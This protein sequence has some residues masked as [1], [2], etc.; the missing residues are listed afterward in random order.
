MKSALSFS[1]FCSL[2][3]L[4]AASTAYATSMNDITPE[5]RQDVECMQRT[6][7]SVPGVDGTEI[8][9][10]D[11]DGWSHPF[12]QYLAPPRPYGYRPT[13]RF[14]AT[15]NFYS[16]S[17]RKPFFIVALSGIASPGEDPPTYG[18]G[19]VAKLWEEKCDVHAMVLFP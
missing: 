1:A 8:G 12:I 17:D 9:V 15:K 19:A 6:L 3:V 13:I 7:K 16:S 11:T 2:A 5:L 10:S 18:T 4:A 14:E